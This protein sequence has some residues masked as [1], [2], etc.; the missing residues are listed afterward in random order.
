MEGVIFNSE[1][2]V[3]CM[4][5]PSAVTFLHCGHK[6][7]CSSCSDQVK[8]ANMYCPLCRS[9]ISV[10]SLADDNAFLPSE[11]ELESFGAH[12]EEY[13]TLLR[14]SCAKNA[15]YVGSGKQARSVGRAMGSELEERVKENAGTDRYGGMKPTFTVDGETFTV[16][17]R[18]QGKRKPIVETYQYQ[19]WEQAK[20]AISELIR[21]DIVGVATHYPEYFW[22]TKY[23]KEMDSLNDILGS[24][25]RRVT[26]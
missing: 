14:R 5:M 2:C 24:N 6:C 20:E 11:K 17:Y 23:H 22:L 15:G 16:S 12:R 19:E 3:I 8:K 1:E 25:K 26:E 21:E 18:V 4:E 7:T 9:D 13:L 10:Y